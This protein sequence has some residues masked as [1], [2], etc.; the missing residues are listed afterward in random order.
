MI[1][2]GTDIKIIGPNKGTTK[3]LKYQWIASVNADFPDT[4][5]LNEN[6][7][8]FEIGNKLM[9]ENLTRAISHETIHNILWYK[10]GI[11]NMTLHD[12]MMQPFKRKIKKTCKKTHKN[13]SNSF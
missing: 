12:K 4:I 11:K 10:I 3:G 7:M 2:F 9:I 1:N 8:W 6:K 13:W 5:F